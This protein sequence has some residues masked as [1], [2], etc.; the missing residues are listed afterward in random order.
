[1]ETT[2]V[3]RPR[4]AVP[5]VRAGLALFVLAWLFGPY[6][7][8]SAVPIWIPFAVALALELHFFVGALRAP[9]P[10]ETSRG[11]QEVDR[12]LYGYGEDVDELLLVRDREHGRDLW[13]PYSGETP[14]EVDELVAEA[15]ERAEAAL[16]APPPDV[17]AP[18]RRLPVRR[19]LTGLAV[20]GVLAAVV[21]LVDSRSGWKGL[22]DGTRAEAAAR[23]SAEA[24]QIAGRPVTIRCDESGDY[25]GAVQHADGVAAV[26][27]ELAFLTPAICSDL[28]RL[29]F[30]DEVVFS[31]TARAIAVLAHESWHLRGVRD[32]GRTECYALQ[33]GV[34]LGRRL[35]LSERTARRMMRQQLAENRLRGVASIEYVVPA[36]C[37]DGG[38]LDLRRG[39]S[40]F[41]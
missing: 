17:P 31:R 18:A 1:V 20:I 21:W 13:I 37:R 27:G 40:R 25:V 9:S 30:R 10:R 12:E 39:S 28:Y 2:Q 3:D 15:R 26:G 23:F 16:E 7:L 19:F 24:S 14:E 36:E 33:S 41:P 6:E 11:P 38:A 8:R 35:G 4:S 32:E 29:A 22:S 34:D 5:L